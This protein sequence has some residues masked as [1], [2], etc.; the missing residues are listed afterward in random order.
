MWLG[1]R[2]NRVSSLLI[3]EKEEIQSLTGYKRPSKQIEW[4]RQWGIPHFVAGDGHP[5]VLRSALEP[6][7]REHQRAEGP[8]LDGLQTLGENNHG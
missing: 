1:E 7:R 2:I 3:I 5:R 6:Q 4:L 8:R